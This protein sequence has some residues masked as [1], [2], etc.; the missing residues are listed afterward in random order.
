MPS[1]FLNIDEWERI[2]QV[3]S[4]AE[5]SHFEFIFLITHIPLH[6]NTHTCTH[7]NTNMGMFLDSCKKPYIWSPRC[8]SLRCLAHCHKNYLSRTMPLFHLKCFYTPLTYYRKQTL[9]SEAS[10]HSVWAHSLLI[11]RPFLLPP[12]LATSLCSWPLLLQVCSLL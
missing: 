6:I 1:P 12:A 10:S 5:M 7:T 11:L 9:F 8:P 2:L 3:C 4:G